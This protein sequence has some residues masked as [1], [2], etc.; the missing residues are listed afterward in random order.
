MSISTGDR[1]DPPASIH[2]VPRD[3]ID[4]IIDDDLAIERERRIGW[5]RLFLFGVLGVIATVLALMLVDA[6][7]MPWYV[8]L[9]QVETVPN[10]AGM[11]FDEA[12]KRLERLGFEVKKGEPR[13]DNR[14]P[15]GA[16]VMQSPYGGAQTKKGR[17][18]YLTLSRGTELIPV[19]DLLGMQIRDARINLMR[20]GLELGEVIYD[21]NDT[22]MK[23]LVF[24]QNIPARLG[25]RPGT[26]VD[27]MV[28]RGPST[29]FVMMPNLLSLDI[30]QARARLENAGLVL[31]VVR[32]K[33]D[34]VYVKNTIIEQGFAPYAQVA[35]G[36]AVDLTI[37]GVG[38]GDE[39]LATDEVAPEEESAPP[40]DRR[41]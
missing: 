20:S 28:S 5:G 7:V 3:S 18:V 21:H 41:P 35:Q 24:A 22:I 11:Q 8:K 26:I 27:V 16:V 15:A 17:R 4:A 40:P 36:A 1:H 25:A 6:V 10:V 32:Y 39:G 33:D 34:P 29:R 19:P 38:D 23:G 14:Y 31:G 30:D 12:R 9:G 2:G 37:C 13:F